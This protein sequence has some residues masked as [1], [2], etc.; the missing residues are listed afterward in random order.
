M[1]DVTSIFVKGHIPKMY[2]CIPVL[3]VTL[4]IAMISYEAYILIVVDTY[5]EIAWQVKVTVWC[6]GFESSDFR[7]FLLCEGV[8]VKD[9]Y[10]VWCLTFSTLRGHGGLQRTDFQ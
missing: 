4:L 5:M 7:Q 3:L 9:I 8:G 1:C 10:C 2:I 6:G